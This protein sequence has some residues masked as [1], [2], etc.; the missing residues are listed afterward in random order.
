[1]KIEKIENVN[2]L[3]ADDNK[4]LVRKRDLDNESVN[5]KDGVKKVWLA[6]SES[7]DDW[8]EID[9]ENTEEIEVVDDG[10]SNIE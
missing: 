5:A 8:L 4:V 10:N 3:I 9:E 1:M 6:K 7:P 2:V